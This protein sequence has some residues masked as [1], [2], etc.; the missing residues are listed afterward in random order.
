MTLLYIKA[1]TFNFLP[2]N[3]VVDDF[4]LVTW[5]P[6]TALFVHRSWHGFANQRYHLNDMLF[7]IITSKQFEY[8]NSDT[9]AQVAICRYQIEPQLIVLILINGD[10]FTQYLKFFIVVYY[11]WKEWWWRIACC[12]IEYV[13]SVLYDHKPRERALAEFRRNTNNSFFLL[14]YWLATSN[15]S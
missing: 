7:C 13:L 5:H 9:S 3:D 4:L 1:H 12:V 6:F 8:Y 15:K 11:G 10:R 2:C 14:F